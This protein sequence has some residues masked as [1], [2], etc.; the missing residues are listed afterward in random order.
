MTA[1]GDPVW[2]WTGLGWPEGFAG[3]KPRCTRLT[4]AKVGDTPVRTRTAVVY[5]R[6]ARAARR[7][8]VV[9]LARAVAAAVVH[10]VAVLPVLAGAAL[11]LAH[12]LA[13]HDRALVSGARVEN[14]PTQGGGDQGETGAGDELLHARR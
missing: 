6:G 8:L 1:L 9:V 5:R 7:T 11:A 12:R 4:S 3:S 13:A 10:A 2:T 14:A